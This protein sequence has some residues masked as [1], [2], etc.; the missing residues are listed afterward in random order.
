MYREALERF[1]GAAAA[2]HR[3]MTSRRILMRLAHDSR[4]YAATLAIA[5]AL[6]TL[7]GL[8]SLVPPWAFSQIINHVIT[9]RHPDLHVLY[10]SLFVIFCALILGALSTYGQTYLMAWSGQHLIARMRAQLFERI[11]RLP[12]GEFAKWRPG[13]LI[14]RFNSDLQIMTD[15]VTVSLPQ[16]YNNMVTFISSLAAMIVIDWLLTSSLIVVAPIVSLA[17]SRFQL[18]IANSTS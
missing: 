3:P 1:Q 18:L 8:T 13:D 11:L 9:A 5:I 17:V 10:V 2:R 16:L 12:L 6:G 15:A 4:P 7:A 14:A